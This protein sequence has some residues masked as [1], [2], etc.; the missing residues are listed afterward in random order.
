MEPNICH[1]CHVWNPGRRV[2]TL[3]YLTF[4]TL[5]CQQPTRCQVR[6]AFAR[7]RDIVTISSGLLCPA[8][9]QQWLWWRGT[10]DDT[11][12]QGFY[13]VWKRRE[14]LDG[15]IHDC[16]MFS[17]LA[18]Q[19]CTKPSTFLDKLA[20]GQKPIMNKTCFWTGEPIISDTFCH[21]LRWPAC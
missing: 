7:Q 4:M 10:F 1:P 20:V 5:S 16:S 14:N 17:A 15:L 13:F 6:R 21:P 12:I 9:K 3:S 8:M 2:A 19:Y 11:K 18:L